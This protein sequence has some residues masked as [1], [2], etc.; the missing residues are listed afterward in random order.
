V[1]L[2]QNSYGN[3]GTSAGDKPKPAAASAT[4][5][6]EAGAKR[7][8]CHNVDVAFNA[9]GFLLLPFRIS[10]WP[11]STVGPPR[12]VHLTISGVPPSAEVAVIPCENPKLVALEWTVPEPSECKEEDVVVDELGQTVRTVAYELPHD[13]DI[14]TASLTG[15]LTADPELLVVSFDVLVVKPVRQL[16]LAARNK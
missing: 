5:G 8:R 6:T 14:N 12:Q 11:K 13:V 3:G 10:V 4:P 7:P 1:Y 16:K 2:R 15:D 9:R